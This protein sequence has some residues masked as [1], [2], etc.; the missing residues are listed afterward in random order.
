[1]PKSNVAFSPLRRRTAAGAS[2]ALLAYLVLSVVGPNLLFAGRVV[3][4][5]MPSVAAETIGIAAAIGL[6]SAAIPALNATR[7]DIAEALRATI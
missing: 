4:R 3:F 7:R 2:G 6:L 1:M 5:L